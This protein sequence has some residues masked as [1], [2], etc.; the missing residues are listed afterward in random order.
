MGKKDKCCDDGYQNLANVLSYNN[1]PTLND[2]DTVA[3]L[4][5]TDS[6]DWQI[7]DDSLSLICKHEGVWLVSTLFQVK[8]LN[9]GFGIIKGWYS[10]NNNYLKTTMKDISIFS[11]NKHYTYR[12]I[13]NINVVK[14]FNRG[15]NL[16]I[17][18]K[19]KN[20]TTG[21]DPNEL[22]IQASGSEENPSLIVTMMKR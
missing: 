8:S 9:D 16:Q 10:L 17:I 1:F 4:S 6:E 12:S 13:L 2:T 11:D 7:S 18:T 5:F 19:T 15:D 20:N 21:G 3:P 22:I 14:H